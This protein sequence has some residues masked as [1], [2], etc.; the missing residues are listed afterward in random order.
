MARKG[1]MR[2]DGALAQALE[3]LHL[4]P[5]LRE[6]RAIALWAEV[7]GPQVAEAT[8]VEGLRDGVIAVVA[9]SSTWAFE[10]T[11]HKERI[12]REL[13][14]RVGRGTVRDLRFR[15]GALPNASGAADARPAAP[16]A[17]A[18]AGTPLPEE[19][20]AAIDAAIADL[21]DSDLRARLKEALVTE[22][23]R[24]VWL[25]E[26]GYRPCA[27]C[28]AMHDRATADCPACLREARQRHRDQAE[29][30]SPRKEST[31]ADGE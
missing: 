19:T 9:R 30:A 14:V 5:V 23:L 7:V 1:L 28:G 11:F 25:R 3:R 6:A 4:E 16:D 12:L 22:R 21:P 27:R 26:H 20:T 8:R 24:D 15:V 13:N 10:L 29:A 31:G 17:S 2:L 18:L